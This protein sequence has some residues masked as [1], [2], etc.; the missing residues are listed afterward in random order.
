M[1]VL[2]ETGGSFDQSLTFRSEGPT[3][4]IF[5]TD[6]GRIYLRI[7]CEVEEMRYRSPAGLAGSDTLQRKSLRQ[8]LRD[9][10]AF[11]RFGGFTGS[12]VR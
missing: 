3:K 5:H 4:P 12:Y 7:N 8:L 2:N 11:R 9:L 6:S 10:C 1:A